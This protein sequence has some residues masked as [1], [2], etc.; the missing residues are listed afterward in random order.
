VQVELGL[1]HPVLQVEVVGEEVL[2]LALQRLISNVQHPNVFQIQVHPSNSSWNHHHRK[3]KML[4]RS[5][6]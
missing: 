4:M 1:L 3:M 2:A 6:R 5:K